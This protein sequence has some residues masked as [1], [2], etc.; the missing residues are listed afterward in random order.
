MGKTA[1]DHLLEALEDLGEQELKRFKG[2][3]REVPIKAG[4]EHIPKGR[5]EK[6]DPLDL[7][8]LLISFYA[9]DYALEL[10]AKVLAEVHCKPQAERLR[11]RSGIGGCSYPQPSVPSAG[12]TSGTNGS[13]FIDRYREDLINRTASVEPV[14]DR[15]HSSVITEA[16][17]QKICAKETN[18]EK[19]RE[20]YKLMPSW[21][22]TCKDKLYEALKSQNP[23]LIDDLEGK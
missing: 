7:A 18:Q 19:M 12:A 5:L 4:Y 22:T 21:N 23:Y 6:A 3:L 13:H 11:A 17:Y 14:L 16:Q 10:A 1:W 15:L 9:E 8:E 2:K 20:L